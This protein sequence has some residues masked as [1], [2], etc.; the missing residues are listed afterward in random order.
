MEEEGEGEG[1][2][3]AAVSPKDA[4]KSVTRF[5]GSPLPWPWEDPGGKACSASR[6]PHTPDPRQL[7][8]CRSPSVAAWVYLANP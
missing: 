2:E 6:W 3:E 5:R 8:V 1:R 4:S 7:L